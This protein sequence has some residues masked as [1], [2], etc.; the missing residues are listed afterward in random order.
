MGAG[1][2]PIDSPFH[3]GLTQCTVLCSCPRKSEEIL[4]HLTDAGCQN[5][6]DPS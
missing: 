6:S 5:A 2:R 4:A 3:H 1:E